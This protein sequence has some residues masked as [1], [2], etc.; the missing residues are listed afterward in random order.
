MQDLLLL[1][2]LVL[3]VGHLLWIGEWVLGPHTLLQQVTQPHT[4]VHICPQL[5]IHLT[6]LCGLDVLLQGQNLI[7]LQDHFMLELPD[8]ALKVG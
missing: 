6:Q 3:D 7:V 8:L 1:R 4:L 2:K 5:K